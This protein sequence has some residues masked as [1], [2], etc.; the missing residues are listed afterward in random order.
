MGKRS[1][2]LAPL[3][4]HSRLANNKAIFAYVQVDVFAPS[5]EVPSK[6]QA[7]IFYFSPSWVSLYGMYML[8]KMFPKV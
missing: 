5:G 2:N 6:N 3:C 4:K 7:H 8:K 1:Q